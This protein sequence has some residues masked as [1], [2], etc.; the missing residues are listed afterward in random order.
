MIVEYFEYKDGEIEIVKSL[1]SAL[2]EI[3]VSN[4]RVATQRL[5]ENKRSSAVNEI[6]VR[7]TSKNI[8]NKEVEENFTVYVFVS[9]SNENVAYKGANT[10]T[11]QLQT[12]L[13]LI[14]SNSNHFRDIF[15]ISS[16]VFEDEGNTQIRS[17]LF[18]AISYG[19]SKRVNK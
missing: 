15:N 3:G 13:K 19:V 11:I 12:A 4:F 1:K 5:P 2:E 6:I 10:L 16:S 8:L 7:S 9:N 18:S 14:K 17:V